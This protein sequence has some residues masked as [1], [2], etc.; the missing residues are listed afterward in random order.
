VIGTKRL[1]T[2][3]GGG[4]GKHDPAPQIFNLGIIRRSSRARA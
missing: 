4:T 1:V 3:T 2:L